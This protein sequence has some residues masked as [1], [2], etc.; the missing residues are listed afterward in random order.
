MSLLR[1]GYKTTVTSISLCLRALVRK[2][3]FHVV[4]GPVGGPWGKELRSLANSKVLRYIGA[5]ALLQ[6]SLQV[7]VALCESLSP[8]CDQNSRATQHHFHW[9]SS[10]WSSGK[11]PGSR[12]GKTESTV[13][14][15]GMSVSL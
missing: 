14:V 2:A 9:G 1:L 4:S 7:F 13:S 8:L 3:S 6:S 11:P 5:R 10:V 15:E 12:G